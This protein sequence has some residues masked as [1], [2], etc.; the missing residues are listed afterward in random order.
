[1][2]REVRVRP[3]EAAGYARFEGYKAWGVVAWRD[4]VGWG[5]VIGLAVGG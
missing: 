5:Y 4:V 2:S 3:R 1:M